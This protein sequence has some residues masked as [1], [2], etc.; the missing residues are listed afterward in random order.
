MP[1]WP[2]AKEIALCGTCKQ[3]LPGIPSTPDPKVRGGF[4]FPSEREQTLLLRAE[5]L[6]LVVREVPEG[7]RQPA[8]KA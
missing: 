5:L 2:R 4:M 1:E 8:H 3:L 6:R 7:I